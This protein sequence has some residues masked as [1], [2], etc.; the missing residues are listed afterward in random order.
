MLSSNGWPRYPKASAL[1][2][3]VAQ[4]ES[5]SKLRF[6]SSIS[7]TFVSLFEGAD[8]FKLSH[9]LKVPFLWVHGSVLV[10]APFDS[11]SWNVLMES[12]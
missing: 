5:Q 2:T 8:K 9:N 7:S 12:A 11:D 3:R 10:A 4:E 6:L 1:C